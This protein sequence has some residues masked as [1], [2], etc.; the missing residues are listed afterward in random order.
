MILVTVAEPKNVIG[1][2]DM[3]NL[4]IVIRYITALIVTKK[5][6]R[7]QHAIKSN[8]L[9]WRVKCLECHK[10]HDR[11]SSSILRTEITRIT[12]KKEEKCKGCSPRE[13]LLR[14]RGEEES[15]EY[16]VGTKFSFPP[17]RARARVIS[18]GQIPRGESF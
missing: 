13:A 6:D 5:D 10:V 15:E 9:A 16:R 3:Q 8:C 11:A 4:D 14:K 7:V 17:S 2:R 1:Y 12:F 18:I